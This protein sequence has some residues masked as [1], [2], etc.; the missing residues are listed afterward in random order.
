M[1]KLKCVVPDKTW[2][3]KAA[4]S[5]KQDTEG[6]EADIAPK[7]GTGEGTK[8]SNNTT[9]GIRTK[10][11][12]SF[13]AKRQLYDKMILVVAP[14]SPHI[15]IIQEYNIDFTAVQSVPSNEVRSD[16]RF[17]PYKV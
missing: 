3:R 16:I 14:N 7:N 9:A 10:V 13:E 17:F 8:S 6:H 4:I 2:G 11:A 15:S 12:P 1:H 5:A